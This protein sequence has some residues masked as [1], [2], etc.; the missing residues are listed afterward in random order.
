MDCADVRADVFQHV[1]LMCTFVPNFKIK[2]RH[3]IVFT[4]EFT[5]YFS[6][7]TLALLSNVMS[8]PVRQILSA[9]QKD[10]LSRRQRL[11]SKLEQVIDTMALTS[12]GP[13]LSLGPA[14][15]DLMAPPPSHSHTRIKLTDC[16][17][18]SSTLETLQPRVEILIHHFLWTRHTPECLPGRDVRPIGLVCFFFVWFRSV[19][20][21]TVVLLLT[22][23]VLYYEP[24]DLNVYERT[25]AVNFHQLRLV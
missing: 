25:R 22:K 15:A 14:L 8:F 10:E 12:W 7:L 2:K 24:E 18:R 23:D 11:R 13:L 1:T 5:M 19:C 16:N 6:I 4:L 9:L 20:W 17:D 3:L 21:A